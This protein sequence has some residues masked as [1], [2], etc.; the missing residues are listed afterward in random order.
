[1]KTY[2]LSVLL[3]I[4][5]LFSSSLSAQKL[6]AVETVSKKSI[7]I[8][9]YPN[10]IKNKGTIRFNLDKVSNVKVEFFDICGKK[11]KEIN[12]TTLGAGRHKIIFDSNELKQGIYFCKV[13][14]SLWNR[15][16][17]IVIKQ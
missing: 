11:V 16:K 17:R 5:I 1:M 10:P 3:L 15:T 8:S 2:I 12:K 14:T 13:S 9:V 4:G 6:N 7:P